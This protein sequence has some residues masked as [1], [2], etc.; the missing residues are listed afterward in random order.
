MTI[1]PRQLKLDENWD[2]DIQN[3]ELVIARGPESV[4]QEIASRCQMFTGDWPFDPRQGVPFRDIIFAKGTTEAQIVQIFRQV[5][6]AT[7][8]V[9]SIES[10]GTVRDTTRRVL[11]LRASVKLD[12][13]YGSLEAPVLV[14]IEPNRAGG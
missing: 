8:G 13:E 6:L 1:T 5:I 12:R 14:E 7:P 11:T 4:V 2:L 9:L 3:G 10:I